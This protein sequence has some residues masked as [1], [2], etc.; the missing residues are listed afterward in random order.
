MGSLRKGPEVGL[1]LECLRNNRES[2]WLE[3]R[4]QGEKR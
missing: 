2:V 1:F 4:E 3:G